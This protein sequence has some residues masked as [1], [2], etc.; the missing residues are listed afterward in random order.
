MNPQAILGLVLIAL[1][2]FPVLFF[3]RMSKKGPQQSEKALHELAKKK[4]FQLD[5]IETWN[6]KALGLDSTGRKF[7]FINRQK[8]NPVEF[9]INL[10]KVRACKIKEQ[11]NSIDLLFE[12]RSVREEQTVAVRIF[13]NLFDEAMQ[14]GRHLV[15]AK[16]WKQMIEA[17]I[18]DQTGPVRKSA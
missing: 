9:I 5:Q 10:K 18:N 4:D 14:S 15:I 1:T 7:V 8:D 2:L 11:M 17:V 13:D 3:I 16:R 12:S 6:Q